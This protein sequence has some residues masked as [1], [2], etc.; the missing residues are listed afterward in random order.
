MKT[1]KN[2]VLARNTTRNKSLFFILVISK[3]QKLLLIHYLQSFFGVRLLFAMQHN[4][5]IFGSGYRAACESLNLKPYLTTS[6]NVTVM[7]KEDAVGL[8]ET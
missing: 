4:G 8:V 2:F 1:Y 5:F 3:R 7:H 6:C